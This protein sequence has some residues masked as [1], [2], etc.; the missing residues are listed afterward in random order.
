MRDPRADASLTPTTPRQWQQ[1]ALQLESPG[2]ASEIDATPADAPSRA[3][4]EDLVVASHA[5]D[6]LTQREVLARVYAHLAEQAVARGRKPA[7]KAQET[8]SARRD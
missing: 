5:R 7:P 1:V 8:A 3:V 4:Q 2:P 6:M